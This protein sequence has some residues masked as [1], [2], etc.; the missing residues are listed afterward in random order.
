M[1]VTKWLKPSDSGSRSGGSESVQ[2]AQG[3]LRHEASKR[4][5]NQ[6]PRSS[7]TRSTDNSLGGSLL[8][9]C[10]APSGRTF[11]DRMVSIPCEPVD[12]APDQ[13]MRPQLLRRT[14][15]FVNVALPIA[16]TDASRRVTEQ[17]R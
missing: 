16:D 13:K 6:R 2:A 11:G 8:H 7:A 14:E 5:V 4:P 10:S 15:E 3:D 1:E 17:R 9:W 12:T